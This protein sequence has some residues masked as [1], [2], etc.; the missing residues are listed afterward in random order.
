[1]R[2]EALQAIAL[3]VAQERAVDVILSQIVGGLT[4]ETGIALARVWLKGPGDRCASC[5]MLSECP[6]RTTCLHLVASAGRS[7]TG[8]LWNRLDGDFARIPLGVRKI[9]VVAVD[10]NPMVIPELAKDDRW[11]LRPEW[12]RRERIKSFAGQPLVF[13]GEVLGVLAV[14]SRFSL[15]EARARLL[16]AFA[17]HAAI[18]I[19]NGRFVE[20]I[21]RLKEQLEVENSY[22]RAE[23]ATTREMIGTSPLLQRVLEQI[24]VIAP[25]DASVLITGESGTGKE[26][27]AHQIHERSRR[28]GRPFIKVNCAAV[29]RELF[30]SEFFGHARGAFTGAVRDRTGRFQAADGGT[31]FLDEVGEIPYEQQ[32]KLLRVIQEGQFER[33]GEERTR[34]ADVRI[35]AASNRDL[36]A[37][38]NAGRFRRDLYYRLNVI[39]IELPPLRTR[40]EDISLL[41]NHFLESSARRLGV[42]VPRLTAA[43]LR[44]LRAQPWPGNIRELENAIERAMILARAGR[45]RFDFLEQRERA[46]EVPRRRN[47]QR[48]EDRRAQDRRNLLAALEAAAGKIYGPDGAA[49]LLG[50]KPTTLVSRLKRYGLHQPPGTTR[51][52]R[53]RT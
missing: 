19:A 23:V 25:T 51:L 52:R 21:Q 31:L 7:T 17:D 14:F 41:S 34:T 13:R 16:R 44:C 45:L 22:L 35:I 38:V 5:P 49:A 4:E 15:D 50:L 37:E 11:I 30:E 24:V 29:P 8:Q 36:A 12:A 42:P 10:G 33:V 9:G 3:A 32:A 39:P 20:E 27:V 26:L 43:D 2:P 6:S 46:D 28:K 1:M 47:V 18:A 53:R 40:P 48:E